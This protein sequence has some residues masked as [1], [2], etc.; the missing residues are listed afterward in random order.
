M[1]PVNILLTNTTL[2]TSTL[3]F[4]DLPMMGGRG[5]TWM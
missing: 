2:V 4:N 1:T 5:I 3:R